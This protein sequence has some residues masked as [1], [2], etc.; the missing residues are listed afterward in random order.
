MI[1]L[2]LRSNYCIINSHN[3]SSNFY[4]RDYEDFLQDL[5]E[6]PA[7]REGVNIYKNAA[8]PVE[9]TTTDD[10]GDAP[11]VSLQ[12]ML[13]DLTLTETEAEVDGAEWEDMDE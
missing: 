7:Y 8:A 5:E 1:E 11:K 2:K 13:D 6:D 3:S 10:E 9:S 4:Y 12:E